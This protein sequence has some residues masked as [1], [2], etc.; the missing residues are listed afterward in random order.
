MQQTGTNHY[1]R[2]VNLTDVAVIFAPFSDMPA[3]TATGT[4]AIKVT[5]S[6]D[7]CPTLTSSHTSLCSDKKTV[8]VTAVDHDHGP[9]GA[10]FMFTVVPDGTQGKWDVEDVNGEA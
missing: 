8:Y 2:N 7:H 5:D 1:H 9:N 6:N 3:K 4:I 10:P